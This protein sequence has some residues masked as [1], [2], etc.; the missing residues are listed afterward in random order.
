MSSGGAD[1]PG[2][3]GAVR[4]R[5][6]WLRHGLVGIAALVALGVAIVVVTSAILLSGATEIGLV[7][8]RVEA[9]LQALLG[10]PFTVSVGRTV[11]RL[12]SE[13][14]LVTDIEDVA[15]RDGTGALVL[16]LPFVELAVDALSLLV[17]RPSV[18]R[19]ALVDPSVALVRDG[20]GRVRLAGSPET[21]GGGEAPSGN[22]PASLPQLA[23]AVAAADRTLADALAA[24]AQGDVEILLRGGALTIRDAISGNVRHV[25]A[26]AVTARI[27]PVG[28]AIEADVA[29]QGQSGAWSASLSRRIAPDTGDRVLSGAFEQVTL[30][31]L[32]LGVADTTVADIPLYGSADIVVDD[33]GMRDAALRLDVGAGVLDLGGPEEAILLD[34]ASLRAR[35][36]GAVG[37]IVV[38][39][40]S[41]HIG[42]TGGTFTGVVRDEGGGRYAFAFE[43][44]DAVLAP[45]DSG[46]PPLPVESLEVSGSADLAARRLDL[47]RLVVQTAEGTLAAAMR[48]G[49]TGE[50]PSLAVAAELTP[51]AIATWLRMWPPSIAPGV[52]RWAIDNIAGGRIAA[53]RFDASVPAGVLF[54]PEPPVVAADALRLDL[55]LEDV[56]V[57]TFGGLPPISRGR[58]RVVL[59]GATLGVDL[60]DGDVVTPAGAVV[61]V[62]DGAFAI[63]DV[64]DP[65]ADGVVEVQLAGT[66]AAIG[67]IA[68]AEP[69]RALARRD[70]AP[71][72]LA[73]D[74][75]AAVSVRVPLELAREDDTTWKV[76]VRG[77]GLASARPVDG[78]IFR[79]GDLTIVVTPDGVTVNG[80]A[81]IDGLAAAV[82][83]SQPLAPDGSDAGGGQQAASLALDR[84]ARVRLGLEIEDIVS[85]TIDAQVRSR[86][87]GAG[88]QYDLDFR[89]AGLTLPGLGW[90]KDVGVPATMR[91]DLRPR[92]GG[93]RAENIVFSGDGFGLVGSAEISD[94]EGLVSA[95]LQQVRLRPG[96][97]LAV[98][99]DWRD[100]RYVVTAEGAAFDLR[101]VLGEL[102][103]GAAGGEADQDATDIT[104]DGRIRKLHGYNGRVVNDATVAFVLRDGVMRKLETSGRLG[105]APLAFAFREEIER[106]SL[107]VQAGNGGALLDYL[108]LY[109][110]IG[111]G[112][113]AISG[114]RPSPSG[115]LAGTFALTDFAILNEPAM[116][117]VVSHAK[118]RA[119]EKIDTTRTSVEQM[120]A[121]FRYEGD[122]VTIDD[123]FLRGTSMGATFNG[124]F[125]L[126]A[127]LVSISGTYIPMFGLNNAF[128]R[129]PV[130][131]RILGGE[132]GQGLIGVTFKVEGPLASPRVLVNPLSAVAPGILRRIFEFR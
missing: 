6:P 63:D 101:G 128:S 32:L 24:S 33:H 27:D 112:R 49:F 35:W 20:A 127:S 90:S 51:M 34:E 94:A 122:R 75:E 10:P 83:L 3:R 1:S 115:P 47:D 65:G 102:K 36:D 78:R 8:D 132:N 71:G 28:G 21:G 5:R 19:V 110:R 124:Y 54:R 29:A 46:H 84:A 80:T 106:A 59:A 86:P 73:G 92:P 60:A 126:A 61:K 11:L 57:A 2:A 120:T 41:V 85:G 88:D 95:R 79:S 82:S 67:E 38:E 45:R 22:A 121:V 74:V 118:P 69:I 91:F 15:V 114:E 113:L 31:D 99:I 25:A 30:G 119:D 109:G 40:S 9:R 96:D 4:R 131:G 70:L 66:A 44:S 129:V 39:P 100:G 81:E 26:I 87:D 42:P 7:R 17:F 89:R 72:D 104:F 123:A 97:D 12:D 77:T 56:T 125:D 14:G 48:L 117:E 37:E 62:T 103:G 107:E 58:G 108:D 43:S 76:T 52:R 98:A 93:A 130:V 13:A 116:R 16:S 50:T 55:A 23:D 53:A 64:F 68:D 18:T 105:G 111:G